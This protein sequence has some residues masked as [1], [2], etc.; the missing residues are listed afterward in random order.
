MP[1]PPRDHISCNVGTL[2][3]RQP[4]PMAAPTNL[5]ETPESRALA[6]LAHAAEAPLSESQLPSP[7][8]RSTMSSA[9]PPSSCHG[10]LARGSST[11]PT[12]RSMLLPAVADAS[13]NDATR[14]KENVFAVGGQQA[15]PPKPCPA[16]PP[17]PHST[18]GDARCDLRAESALKASR[19]KGP[20][21]GVTFRLGG[22]TSAPHNLGA[23]FACSNRAHP[24]VTRRVHQPTEECDVANYGMAAEQEDRDDGG[25]LHRARS[26]INPTNGRTTAAFGAAWQRTHQ[27]TLVP[28]SCA[29]SFYP[30][31]APTFGA[32]PLE[33]NGNAVVQTNTAPALARLFAPMRQAAIGAEA[34]GACTPPKAPFCS[35]SSNNCSG[36]GV[37]CGSSSSRRS[38]FARPNES[39][40][41]IFELE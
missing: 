38:G 11:T 5:A 29:D 23:G 40:D 21:R 1:S 15:L 28:S 13:N 8:P 4:K 6:E 35:P 30:V 7:I 31:A 2:F 33:P 36:G 32:C 16:S 37:T 9:S 27:H 41:Y 26:S 3:L 25:N 39:D 14:M 22:A 10:A 17:I 24:I 12:S 20:Q 18:A 34:I 19:S